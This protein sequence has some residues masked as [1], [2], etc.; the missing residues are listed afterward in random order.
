VPPAVPVI[1]WQFVSC[2]TPDQRTGLGA[3]LLAVAQKEPLTGSL[4]VGAVA[5]SQCIGGQ[6]RGGI[7]LASTY[8]NHTLGLQQLAILPPY[9][10][11]AFRVSRGLIEQHA[12]LLWQDAQP[13]RRFNDQG[14]VDPNGRYELSGYDIPVSW[15]NF[16]TVHVLD[17]TNGHNEVTID[18]P[19]NFYT[20]YGV[21]YCRSTGARNVSPHSSSNPLVQTVINATNAYAGKTGLPY[22]GVGAQC[23]AGLPIDLSQSPSLNGWPLSVDQ[24]DLDGEGDITVS[25]GDLIR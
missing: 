11:Y 24:T 21:F 2:I 1:S 15:N 25:G 9:K 16:L 18:A 8:G 22:V 12:A 13:Y 20:Q 7:F 6:E 4:A 3:A 10:Q 19:G 23:T 14:I 17:R 5:E